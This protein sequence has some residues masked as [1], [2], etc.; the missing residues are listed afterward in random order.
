VSAAGEVLVACCQLAPRIGEV[1]PNRAAAAAAIEDAAARGAQVVVLPE[2]CVS[3]YVFEDADEA[4]SLAEPVDGPTVTGW[5]TLA[6]RLGVVVVGGVCELDDDGL[7]RNSAV[8]VDADGTV[9]AVYRK[10]HLWDREDVAFAA[11]TEPPPVVDT[12]FGRLG[13][14]V[15]YDLE[16]PEW[17]RLA[18]LGGAELLCAPANWPAAARPDGERAPEVVRT[19]ADASVNRIF[20]AVCDRTGVERGVDWVGGSVV[21]DPDGFPLAGPAAGGEVV[22]VVA[23]CDL[24]RARDKRV[25]AR[26]DVL[27]D[28]RPELYGGVAARG[29]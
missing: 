29:G 26:N 14:M 5:R 19:Q 1:E 20:V 18:A 23:R 25:S 11:G 12:R 28:R 10:A 22:T 13:V 9:G 2:L 15:C 27:A 8:L 6:R 21:V 7:L 4:R 24:A 16:F 17:V 3:G